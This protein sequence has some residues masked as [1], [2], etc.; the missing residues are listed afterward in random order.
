MSR[1]IPEKRIPVCGCNEANSVKYEE[2][3]NYRIDYG[4]QNTLLTKSVVVF[5]QF[6]GAVD[7]CMEEANR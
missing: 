4:K 5:A 7:L 2:R 1:H 6:S 3:A